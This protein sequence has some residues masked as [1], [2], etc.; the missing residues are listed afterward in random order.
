MEFLLEPGQHLEEVDM[1]VSGMSRY[2][3]LLVFADVHYSP[4][5]YTHLQRAWVAM[6]HLV[7]FLCTP[8]STA[9]PM[10]PAL[11]WEK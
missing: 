9:P 8:G 6:D 11:I 4:A 7:E 10:A 3:Q 1:K 2:L 5:D